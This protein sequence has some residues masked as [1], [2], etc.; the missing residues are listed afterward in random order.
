MAQTHTHTGRTHLLVP[1]MAAASVASEELG[2]ALPFIVPVPRDEA[3]GAETFKIGAEALALLESIT[4]PIVPIA[5][6]G[7]ARTGKSYLLNS[8]L[9]RAPSVVSGGKLAAKHG[10]AFAVGST[11]ESCTKG[12]WLYN[13]PLFTKLA[14]GQKVAVCILDSEGFGSAEKDE[15]HDTRVFAMATL[16]CSILVYNSKGVIDNDAVNSLSFVANISRH[17][18]TKASIGEDEGERSNDP[19]ELASLFPSFVWVLRDFHL[20]LIDDEGDP[21]TARDYMEQRL[22]DDGHLDAESLRRNTVRRAVTTFFRHRDCFTLT[23]PVIEEKDLQ[24]LDVLEDRDLRTEFVEGRDALIRRLLQPPLLQLKM[25]NGTAVTG[26]ML[27]GLARSYVAAVNS[28]GVPSVGNAWNSVAEAECREARD[29]CL[30]DLHT[31]VEEVRSRC[32]MNSPELRSVCEETQRALEASFDSRSVGGRSV[33]QP[34]REQL[35]EEIA[36]QLEDLVRFNDTEAER[37]VKSLLDSLHETMMRPRLTRL[38]DGESEGIASSDMETLVAR[39]AESCRGP[40]GIVWRAFAEWLAR[41]SVEMEGALALATRH[42]ADLRVREAQSALEESQERVKKLEMDLE[43]TQIRAESAE[44]R[45]DRSD[46]DVRS[47]KA[48][49]DAKN[50][51]LNEARRDLSAAKDA[52]DDVERKL[53]AAEAALRKERTLRVEAEDRAAE[54]EAR[55]TAAMTSTPGV[56]IPAASKPASHASSSVAA[57]TDV[58]VDVGRKPGSA[59]PPL[60]PEGAAKF[61]APSNAHTIAANMEKSS[62]SCCSVM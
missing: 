42:A 4:V 40:S 38:R 27:A 21:L 14:D 7:R 15:D 59:P 26:K 20:I 60:F 43:A 37:L 1:L 48:S 19:E 10:S 51:S 29:A 36:K 62:G 55:A 58:R 61:G 46:V 47:F 31:T 30:G 39:F 25:L 54:A 5:V 11:V 35:Q 17:I 24:R 34:F 16:L 52:L 56:V 6:C 23:Q 12:I 22:A 33:S 3:G 57:S 32:P 2:T 28:H 53:H 44:S 9:R 49:V 50:E 13:T 41:S 45:A 8:I 18:Q